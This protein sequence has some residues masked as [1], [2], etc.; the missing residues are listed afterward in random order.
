[1]RIFSAVK[2]ENGVIKEITK[3]LEIINRHRDKIKVVPSKNLHLTLRFLG[4]IN[5]EMCENFS[6]ELS[7][8]CSGLKPF[9]INI[10]GIGFFPSR[11]KARVIWVGIDENPVLRKIYI[12]TENA[13]EKIGLKPENKF[14]GHIT[15]GRIKTDLSPDI[16]N[17]LEKNFHD[18]PWGEMIVRK[19]T[20][21][22]S[23]LHPEGSEYRELINI[24]L[25]GN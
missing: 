6:N 10:H 15:V 22:E 3:L 7:K 5:Q 25:G 12:F 24:P 21:F 4:N 23:I 17:E 8:S 16:I 14:Q 2:I 20:I 13:A 9:S 19:I 11:R 1:M 18:R